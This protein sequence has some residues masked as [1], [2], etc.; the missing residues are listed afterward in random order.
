MC[1]L[2]ITTAA[3]CTAGATSGAGMIAVAV[4]RWRALKSGLRSYSR[5]LARICF[6]GHHRFGTATGKIRPQMGQEVQWRDL[7]ANL[8]Q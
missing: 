7:P 8:R 2:C 3:L 6:A 5:G 1:P 4:S